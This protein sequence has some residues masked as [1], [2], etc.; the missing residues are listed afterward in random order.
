MCFFTSLV[1]FTS[2][3]DD[4][5]MVAFADQRASVRGVTCLGDE[6]FVVLLK[7]KVVDVYDVDTLAL[8]RHLPVHVLKKPWDMTSCELNY[9]L[10]ICEDSK[11]RVYQVNTSGKLKRWKVTGISLSTTAE[12]NLLIT[13]IAPPKVS[14]FTKDGRLIKEISLQQLGCD[15]QHSVLL[16]PGQF[17]VCFGEL[18]GTSGDMVHIIN[19]KGCTQLSYRGPRG[20]SNSQM[21]YPHHLAVDQQGSVL[22]ADSN[23]DRILL[24]SS[25]LTFVRELIGQNADFL[26]QPFRMC[27]DESRGLLFVG[28]SAKISRIVV[29]R[30]A[31]DCL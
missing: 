2:H 9:S 30:V 5:L 28:E 13:F 1:N 7:A 18:F 29:F 16:R 14:E 11:D 3:V 4:P 22:V 24:L 31:R 6:V 20:S 19:D 12:S 8:R 23:N 26:R 10:Y 27:F 15:L 25:S 21:N 17:I